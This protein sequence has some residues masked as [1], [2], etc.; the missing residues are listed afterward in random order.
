[1]FFGDGRSNS[2][3][4]LS[5]SFAELSDSVKDLRQKVNDSVVILPRRYK[6]LVRLASVNIFDVEGN[7]IGVAIFISQRRIISALHIF[8]KHYGFKKRKNAQFNLNTAIHGLLHRP[9]KQEER[10]S[11]RVVDYKD[12][13][14]LAVLEL[15]DSYSDA[16]HFVALPAIGSNDTKDN[17]EED[18]DKLAVTSFTSALANQAPNAVDVSFCVCPAALLKVSNHHLLYSSSLFSGDSSGA[19]LLSKD[20]SLR[21]VHQ[22]SVN[23]ASDELRRG[24]TPKDMVKSIN[25]LISGLSSGFIG[26]RLDVMEVQN[27][28]LK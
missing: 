28:I 8:T 20:G 10:A 24:A 16:S 6:E 19:V 11:F 4:E 13:W 14:D 25:S 1:M 7:S 27:F 23:Q 21:G 22:E 15:I 9:N 5:N 26:L 17:E 12:S 2:I 18:L 3:A